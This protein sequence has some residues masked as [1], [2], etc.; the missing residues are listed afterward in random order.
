MASVASKPIILYSHTHGPNPWKI[1][2]LFE[3]L[4][5]EYTPNYLE[6]GNGQN[7]VKGEDFLKVNP[8]GRV[9]AITDPNN[10]NLYV[11]E[12]AAIIQYIQKRYD[13]TNLLGPKNDKEEANIWSW[14]AFQISGLGPSQGQANWFRHYH[15]EK[16][17]KS[18]ID[19]Y[20]EET[21]RTYGVLERRLKDHAYLVGEEQGPD[22]KGRYTIADLI[23]IPWIKISDAAGVPMENTDPSVW[24]VQKD[25]PGVYRWFK[26]IMERDAVKKAFKT[27]S[28]AIAAAAKAKAEA[29]TKK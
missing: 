12:S 17:L 14:I 19:R 3:E 18:A 29:E 13:T 10:D 9:P 22:G 11:W 28:D 20:T 21:K 25:L 1:A 26:R 27:Q 24:S 4:K 5:L 7:G 16:N 23:F 15:A 6:M 2:I 8:N